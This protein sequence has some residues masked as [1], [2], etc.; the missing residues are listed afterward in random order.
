MASPLEDQGIRTLSQLFHKR[1][2]DQ[3]QTPLLAFPRS[4]NG[5]TDFE[6]FSGWTL[7]RFINEAAK[8]LADKGLPLQV[9][10]PARLVPCFFLRDGCFFYFGPSHS[11]P[12]SSP[13]EETGFM[14]TDTRHTKSITYLPYRIIMSR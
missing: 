5:F 3:D 9:V 14:N 6:R 4:K 1:A 8:C 13:K 11:T 12:R 10:R 7:Y 2:L